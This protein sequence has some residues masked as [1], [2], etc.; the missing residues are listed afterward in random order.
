MQRLSLQLDLDLATL[1][2]ETSALLGAIMS[3]ISDAVNANAEAANG[4]VARANKQID[5]LKAENA[6][7][8]A[9]AATP[10][11]VNKLQGTTAVLDGLAPDSGAVV[12]GGPPP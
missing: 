6:T 9:D 7:L 10:E 3:A 2:P 8:K 5:D 12:G 1:S 4:A 11:D